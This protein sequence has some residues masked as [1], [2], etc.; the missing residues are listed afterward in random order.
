[1]EFDSL[2]LSDNPYLLFL[3][4]GLVYGSRGSLARPQ[5]D[6]C[7][8]ALERHVPRDR[9]TA[10][11]STNMDDDDD[12]PL[13]SGPVPF[14]EL[15]D[16]AGRL[17]ASLAGMRDDSVRRCAEMQGHL[18][19]VLRQSR[20]RDERAAAQRDD[21]VRRC[22]EMQHQLTVIL[23]Q[24]QERDHQCKLATAQRDEALTQLR[25]RG[26]GVPEN[27]D[28]RVQRLR[29]ELVEARHAIEELRAVRLPDA[30]ARL[31]HRVDELVQA[32][33][34]LVG[35]VVLSH[36]EKQELQMYRRLHFDPACSPASPFDALGAGIK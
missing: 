20:E 4:A 29:S 30:V 8:A 28:E 35:Q 6:T 13:V 16:R 34:K 31:A 18:A 5:L 24:S 11:V 10:S 32:N 36:T 3:Y 1:M 22:A 26:N 2:A 21:A 33:Q 25:Q 17:A 15:V 7:F 9:S 23:H 14:S 27:G 19:A 12:E